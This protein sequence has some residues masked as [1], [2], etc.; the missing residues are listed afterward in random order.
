MTDFKNIAV[1]IDADN[2]ELKRLEAVLN[3]IATYGHISVKRAYG[4]WTKDV[5]KDWP[6]EIKRL[7]IYP[8]QQFD[9]V[10]KKN[11]SDIA[12]VIDA[13]ELLYKEKYDCF[14]LISSDSDF[15]PLS[16]KIK[17]SSVFVIGVGKAQT[18]ESFRK[19]CD[20]FILLEHIEP[21]TP[22][23]ESE[24]PEQLMEVVPPVQATQTTLTEDAVI[25]SLPE[26]YSLENTHDQDLYKI[27]L[28]VWETERD[29]ENDF[30]LLSKVGEYL[31]KRKTKVKSFGYKKLED[32][33]ERNQ[34][35]YEKRKEGN[36]VSFRIKKFVNQE[37]SN[38]SCTE[39]IDANLQ[40]IHTHLKNA[41]E[42]FQNEEGYAL[43]SQA[44]NYLKRVSPD[45]DTRTYKYKQ[46][47]DLLKDHPKIYKLM[48]N[49]HY[50]C[51]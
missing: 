13:M 50:K 49:Q 27:M 20:D 22:I 43:L 47:L 44:G 9:Y 29:P 12:L 21:L 36:T 17:E 3:R 1:L 14:V 8:V 7:A 15:T 16:I 28:E 10:S 5:L 18:P 51:L 31:K 23:A 45:F 48:G 19:A 35:L 11:A 34:G 4:N 37:F 26:G 24:I 25:E 40:M 32:A 33:I 42:Q 46:L 2:T 30:A 38:N 39:Q 41:W 6:A